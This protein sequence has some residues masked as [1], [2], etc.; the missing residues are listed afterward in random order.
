MSDT[1]NF[2]VNLYIPFLEYLQILPQLELICLHFIMFMDLVNTQ[3]MFDLFF[4]VLCVAIVYFLHF[5][6]MF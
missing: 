5:T 2:A 6:Q 4:Y 1:G 3:I